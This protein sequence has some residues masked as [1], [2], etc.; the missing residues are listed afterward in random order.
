[1]RHLRLDLLIAVVSILV[2]CSSGPKPETTRDTNPYERIQAI[3]P[4]DAK[5][6]RE[7]EDYR[8]WRNP[9]LIIRA[10]GVGLL[11]PANLEE[12]ILKPEELAQAL[13]KLPASAWPYGRV[14]AVTEIGLRASGD[15]VLIRKNRGIV[16]GTLEGMHVLVSIGPPPG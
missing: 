2:S 6:Y 14:V 15:D 13:G 1:M 3:P 8:R 12:H 10:D 7:V 4:A 9:Y 5:K 16:L 11:D